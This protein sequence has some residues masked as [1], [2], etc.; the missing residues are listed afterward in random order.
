MIS[1][2]QSRELKSQVLQKSCRWD[3]AER[4]LLKRIPGVPSWLLIFKATPRQR[5]P[6][7]T[8]QGSASALGLVE[9]NRLLSWFPN[10]FPRPTGP[11]NLNRKEAYLIGWQ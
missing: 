10:N 6:Q 5:Y 2:L 4:G 7:K 8:T 11:P 9:R 1:C 3:P